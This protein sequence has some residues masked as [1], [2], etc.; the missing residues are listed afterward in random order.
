MNFH[1]MTIRELAEKVKARAVS[2]VELTTQSLARIAATDAEIGAFVDTF[3]DRAMADA[4]NAEREIGSGNYL[5]PLH[6]IPI[7]VK[8][9]FDVAGQPTM[10]GSNY[11]SGSKAER[12]AESVSLLRAAG[13]VIIGKTQTHECAYGCTTPTTRNPWNTAHVPGGSSGGS[14]AA[15]AAGDCYLALGSDTGGSIRSPAS[16]CGVYGLKPTYDLVSRNGVVALSWSLD[17]VGPLARSVWDVAAGLT[18]LI[19]R[20]PTTSNQP[21]K[22]DYTVGI[23]SGVAGLRI[24][25]PQDYYFDNIHPDVSECVMASVAL[26]EAQGARRLAPKLP[27]SGELLATHFC[28]MFA[29]ASAYHQDTLRR[30]PA[31]Y[32][33]EVRTLLRIGELLSATEYI[34]AQRARG[35]IQRAW[36]EMFTEIDALVVPAVAAPASR[37]GEDTWTTPDGTTESILTAFSRLAVPANLLGL[38]AIC[39]PS[40]I[41]GASLPVGLQ[42]IA[43]PYHEALLFRIAR[44]HEVRAGTEGQSPKMVRVGD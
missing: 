31:G 39:I 16:H 21:S 44:A 25:I 1:K 22:E 27:Y 36:A 8:D 35:L 40:G 7:A 4:R 41:V 28:I 32:G 9:L 24:G 10:A 38:P 3:S 29:E 19:S 13:A 26:L 43:P 5:G 17:H 34:S 12:D 30:N 2:P 11:A 6:G 15:L 37:I 33:E 23:D 20:P 18:A 14:A 42:I